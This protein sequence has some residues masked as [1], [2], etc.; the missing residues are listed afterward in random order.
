MS[1]TII[2]FI[3]H[4]KNGI[5]AVGTNLEDVLKQAISIMEFLD[6]D[7]F[8]MIKTTKISEHFLRYTRPNKNKGDQ[9]DE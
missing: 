7:T 1:T 4:S 9:N 5:I 8:D 3:A 6:Y 2:E